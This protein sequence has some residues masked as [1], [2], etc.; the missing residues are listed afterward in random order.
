[1]KKI[2]GNLLCDWM[3]FWK[4]EE[5]LCTEDCNECKFDDVCC[6]Y[7]HFLNINKIVKG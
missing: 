5:C 7:Q 1:M 4:S 6:N 2:D 3:V